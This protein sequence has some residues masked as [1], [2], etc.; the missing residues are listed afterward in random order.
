MKRA[1]TAAVL[2]VGLGASMD[3]QIIQTRVVRRSSSFASFSVGWLQQAAFC[4]PTN[5]ACWT[6][7]DAAQYKASFEKSLGPATSAGISYAHAAVPLFWADN[8]SCQPCNANSEI[9]QVMGVLH[10]GTEAPFSQLIDISVGATRFANFKTTAG[11]PLGTGKP[12]TDFSFAIGYGFGARIATGLYFTLVEE[13][14]VAFNKRDVGARSG[15][16]EQQVLRGG[17]RMSF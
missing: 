12:V 3:A 7:S 16:A 15:A 17:L 11:V 9:H 14:G 13:Y 8:G 4:D 6:F 2:I 5:D 1:M 10:M